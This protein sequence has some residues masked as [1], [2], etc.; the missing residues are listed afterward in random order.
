MRDRLRRLVFEPSVRELLEW[1]E[2]VPND[3]LI[4][5]L[6][7]L[8][9]EQLLV[10]SAEGLTQVM[11]TKAY[12]FVRL[13]KIRNRLGKIM[14]RSVLLVEGEEHKVGPS[15]D[16]SVGWVIELLTMIV[17]AVDPEKAHDASFHFSTHQG[18][19]SDLLVQ[20]GRACQCSCQSD[21][22]QS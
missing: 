2:T 21:R 14:G 7:V 13:A 3:G 9:A 12:D 18:P 17:I 20:I 19:I 10:T 4:R 22:V 6:G 11:Q 5:Y 15:T 16:N 8:N 1:M